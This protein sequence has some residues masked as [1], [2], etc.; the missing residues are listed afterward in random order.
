MGLFSQDTPVIGLRG[1]HLDLKGTPPTAE[2]LMELLRVIAAARY[3]V[4][5]VEWEDMF[6]WTV[7]ERFRSET[8]YRP[9]D[10]RRFTATAEELGLEIISLIQCLG[11]METPLSVPGYEHLREVPHRPDVLNPLADGAT[12]LIQRMVDDVLAVTP[13]VRYLHLGGDEAW[14]F[15]THPDTKA[16]VAQHGKGALYLKHVEPILDQL[17][18]RGVR[19]ILWHDM[20]I[21]WDDHALRQL[22]E[23]ADL[24]VWGYCG[25]PDHT[26]HHFNTKYTQRFRASGITC[27]GGA[28]YKGAESHNSDRPDGAVRHLNALAWTEVAQRYDFVGIFATAWSRYCTGGMQCEP[29]DG[30]L[31]S[32]V[33]LGATL[34]DGQAPTGGREACLQ[35]LEELGERQR[36]ETCCAALEQLAEARDHAWQGARHLKEQLA[37]LAHDPHRAGGKMVAVDRLKGLGTRV[38]AAQ[39]AADDVRQGL[40]GRMQSPWVD[41]YL[42]QRISPLTDELT[43]L[44]QRVRQTCPAEYHAELQD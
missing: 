3:N 38:N 37:L 2:R 11:H 28:A 6:P 20:M 12:D 27:W 14:S 18:A 43:E 34:H 17:N 35:I 16:Y 19:P 13:G 36:F 29:I 22:S 10:I 5:L 41:R 21:H 31:D 26:E 40:Q 7:D 39:T 8:A 23:K 30:A 33:N 15:G 1:V 44:D 4:L 32:L 42:A 9:D 24:C 25:Y